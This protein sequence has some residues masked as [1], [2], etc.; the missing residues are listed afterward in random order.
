MAFYKTTQ[1]GRHCLVNNTLFIQWCRFFPIPASLAVPLYPAERRRK[2]EQRGDL[3]ERLKSDIHHSHLQSTDKN[4]TNLTSRASG[5]EQKHIGAGTKSSNILP[6]PQSIHS[7][8]Y[9]AEIYECL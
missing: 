8:K 6:H 4:I 7:S 1:L 9:Y 3:R 2:G 5:N